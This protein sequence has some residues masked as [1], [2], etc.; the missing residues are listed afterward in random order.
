[1]NLT[2][3]TR[4]YLIVGAAFLILFLIGAALAAIF[5]NC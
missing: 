4:A 2:P 1:M 3:T 5:M